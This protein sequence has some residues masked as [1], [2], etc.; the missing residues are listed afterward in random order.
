M[1]QTASYP[2]LGYHF[3]QGIQLY[4]TLHPNDFGGKKVEL[5]IEE[6]GLARETDIGGKVQKLASSG[7]QAILG[8]SAGHVIENMAGSAQMAGIPLLWTN[9]GDS[10]P[11]RELPF[12]ILF[13]LEGGHWQ[14][15]YHLGKWYSQHE[16]Q[17]PGEV[18]DFLDSGYDFAAVFRTGVSP[19]LVEKS[20]TQVTNAGGQFDIPPATALENLS[21]ENLLPVFS[22][23]PNAWKDDYASYDQIARGYR[24]ASPIPGPAL[25]E[26]ISTDPWHMDESMEETTIFMRGC[27]EYFEQDPDPF[28]LLGYELGAWLYAGCKRIEEVDGWGDMATRIETFGK[29][30]LV[31]PRGAFSYHEPL[32]LMT[33]PV[34]ITEQKQGEAPRIVSTVPSMEVITP[35]HSD[36]DPIQVDHKARFINPY[37]VI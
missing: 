10:I 7:M 11:R 28:Y 24:L 4:F 32:Q 27:K 26:Q 6:V 8:W 12:G 33:P 25:K 30:D 31:T 2:Q 34:S 29:V 21:K 13:R 15:S 35:D 14:S 20:W 37:M 22:V 1:P 36:L 5:H 18:F 16:K 3:L 17:S 23:H 19:E 9:L